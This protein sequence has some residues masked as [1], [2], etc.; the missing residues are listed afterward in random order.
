MLQNTSCMTHTM[1]SLLGSLVATSMAKSA[2][3]VDI[4]CINTLG[5]KGIWVRKG[6][7]LIH[8]IIRNYSGASGCFYH[9]PIFVGFVFLIQTLWTRQNWPND[10]VFFDNGPFPNQEDCS[11]M[12]LVRTHCLAP[13]MTFPTPSVFSDNIYSL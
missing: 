4:T 1:R 13:S 8:S 7:G 3:T 10:P 5:Y 6:F 11:A 9:A 2:P 12:P